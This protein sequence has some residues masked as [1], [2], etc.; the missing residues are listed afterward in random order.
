MSTYG[1]KPLNGPQHDIR[2]LT[3]L[4]GSTGEPLKACISHASLIRPQE[5]SNGRVAL[6][7][8]QSTAPH[9]WT[10]YETLAGPYIFEHDETGRTSWKHP[11]TGQDCNSDF[12]DY[13]PPDFE[14][15][16]EALSYTWGTEQ[17]QHVLSVQQ[18]LQSNQSSAGMGLQQLGLDKNL[19]DA[20]QHLRYPNGNRVLWIDAICINQQDTLERNSQVLRMT[21]VYNLAQRVVVWLGRADCNSSRC[22]GRLETCWYAGGDPQR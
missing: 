9:G 5:S 3:L 1:Y 22:S 11:S 18:T 12:V 8:I 4:A 19:F 6:S 15:S 17:S 2:L 21:D 16:Y 14:L 13:P 7:Q 10:A 20:L